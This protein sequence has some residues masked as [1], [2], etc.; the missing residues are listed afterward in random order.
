MAQTNLNITMD[1]TTPIV[2]EECGCETFTQVTF[3]REVSRF[4]AGTDQDAL[5]PIPSFACSKCGHVNEKF[6]P[7]NLEA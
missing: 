2:C 6:Q 3:L 5:V 4:I 1:K 7:K